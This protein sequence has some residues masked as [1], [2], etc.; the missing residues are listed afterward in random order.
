VHERHDIDA[1]LVDRA[2][3]E[4]LP[5]PSGWRAGLRWIGFALLL[6]GIAGVALA[7]GGAHVAHP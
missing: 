3:A 4:V 5:A 1:R 2:A 6:A 7:F